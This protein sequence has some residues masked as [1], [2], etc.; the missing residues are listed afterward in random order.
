M[1]TTNYTMPGNISV[2]NQTEIISYLRE[3][4][5]NQVEN[6]ENKK[7]SVAFINGKVSGKIK[8]VLSLF[9][10]VLL[11]FFSAMLFL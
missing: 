5:F 8:F 7:T 9:Y 4:P 2:L 6:E 10:F 11:I 1:K 3:K